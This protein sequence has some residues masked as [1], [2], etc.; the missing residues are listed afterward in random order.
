MPDLAAT[1]GD[2]TPSFDDIK[3][4]LKQYLPLK[5]IL[6]INTKVKRQGIAYGKGSNFLIGGNTLGRGIA[7]KDLSESH[8][9]FEKLKCRRSTPCI[10]MRECMDI[11]SVT[12]E[13]TRLFIPRH[14]YYRFAIFIGRTKTL[15]AYI[16]NT[17]RCPRPFRSNTPM[18]FVRPHPGVLDVKKIDTLLPGKQIYSQYVV[19][20]TIGVRYRKFLNS[21]RNVSG[22]L[23]VPRPPEW[24]IGARTAC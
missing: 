13:Y 3:A 4:V 11:R 24:R 20:A 19:S 10:S 1:L 14:L 22:F 8:I 18:V 16:E 7:I 23:R 6:V 2:K 9:I 21:C 5:K 15:A 12:I 17:N